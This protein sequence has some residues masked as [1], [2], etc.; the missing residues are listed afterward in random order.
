MSEKERS[1]KQTLIELVEE[2]Q[3]FK[4]ALF[5]WK[6]D[7]EKYRKQVAEF[8]KI[9]VKLSEIEDKQL[10]A[11]NKIFEDKWVKMVATVGYVDSKVEKLYSF[12]ENR[13]VN[14]ITELSSILSKTNNDL[15]KVEAILEQF[16]QGQ[17]KTNGLLEDV[18][19]L[20][21]QQLEIKKQTA[22]ESAKLK[23]KIEKEIGE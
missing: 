17:G 10:Q 3:S 19:K 21:E 2:L 11:Q 20:L 9:F 16:T 6:E 14:L 8:S 1:Y 7:L 4:Y 5:T 12:M 18:K 22:L 13:L 23:K 15:V